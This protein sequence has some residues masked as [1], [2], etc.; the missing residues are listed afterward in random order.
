MRE[1][2]T[3]REGVRERETERQRG[4]ERERERERDRQSEGLLVEGSRTENRDSEQSNRATQQ[5][6]ID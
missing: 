4:S 6:M 3:E 2:E 1:R 5:K